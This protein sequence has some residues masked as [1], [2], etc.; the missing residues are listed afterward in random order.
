[1]DKVTSCIQN[2]YQT[3]ISLPTHG[4]TNFIA[5]YNPYPGV[6]S[7]G[8]LETVLIV[9]LVCTMIISVSYLI[10]KANTK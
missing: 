1:M 5:E 2:A 3:C 6:H 10:Y 7:N 9:G 4:L 8:V